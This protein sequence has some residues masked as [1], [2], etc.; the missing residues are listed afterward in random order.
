M[1][2]WIEKYHISIE[3]RKHGFKLSGGK[4]SRDSKAYMA[5]IVP[6]K[7]K[8]HKKRSKIYK[9]SLTVHKWLYQPHVHA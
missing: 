3:I 1:T 9:R 7:Y 8:I 2:K 6:S 5:S 4:N